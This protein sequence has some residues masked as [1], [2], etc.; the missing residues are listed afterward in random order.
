MAYDKK[1]I[2]DVLKKGAS[3]E[4]N[5][6]MEVLIKKGISTENIEELAIKLFR[7]IIEDIN[8]FDKWI[9]TGAEEHQMIPDKYIK[10]IY[11]LKK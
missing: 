9:K 5:T 6:A 7:S 10:I 11:S 2:E 1:S 4:I 3:I 8:G